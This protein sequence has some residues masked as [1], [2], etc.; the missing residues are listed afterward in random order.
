MAEP[1]AKILVVD[2]EI[3]IIKRME[4]LLLPRHY[5][6][7][8]ASNG[9]AALQLV[10]QEQPDLILLDLLMAGMN[11]F[12]VCHHLKTNP[13]TH[14]IPVILMTALGDVED[15][16]KGLEAGADGFLTKP[17]YRDELLACIQSS[18][19]LGSIDHKAIRPQ[20]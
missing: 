20:S 17:V 8:S 9:E 19:Q 14:S 10:P 11:G 1:K 5:Q 4:A 2:D 18:L 16:V 15:R 3:L 12:E 6:V 13:K 7:I